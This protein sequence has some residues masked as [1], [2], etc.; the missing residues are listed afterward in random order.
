MTEVP[1]IPP[2]NQEL[3]RAI[4]RAGT[5]RLTEPAS[6]S[7]SP[8]QRTTA[9]LEFLFDLFAETRDSLRLPPQLVQNLS[10]HALSTISA[11]EGSILSILCAAVLGIVTINKQLD[12]VNTRL[13]ELPKENEQLREKIQDVS[14]VL[15]NDVATSEELD[16]LNSALLDLSHRVSAPPPPRQPPQALQAQ[17]TGTPPAGPPPPAPG[18]NPAPLPQNL[19]THP[20]NID[21]S[22]HCPYYD[23]NLGKMFGDPE[24]YAKAFPHSWEAE[25][26][27]AGKY[28]LWK[29]TPA[30][31]HPDYKP[32]HLPTYAQAAGSG[33]SWG[34]KRKKA[35]ATEVAHPAGEPLKPAT[36]LP[37]ASRRLFA[38]RE[39][40]LPHPQ[41]AHI[42]KT[43]PDIVATTLTD[44]NCLLPKGFRVKVNDRGAV[45]LSGTDPLTPA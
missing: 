14:S 39:T 1:H 5:P 29:F 7:P 15:A 22:V 3:A 12:T 28:D 9:P 41:A 31:Q 13:V 44:S 36:S 17:Q 11:G 32:K 33:R 10:P 6:A 24:L 21:P 38:V 23:T 8:S 16:P 34:K 37:F 27:R 20:D 4:S 2:G 26:F 43:F 45:S 30:T 42:S 25:Q 35:T 40:P 19:F 18:K